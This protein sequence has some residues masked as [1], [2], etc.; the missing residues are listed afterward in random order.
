VLQSK[1]AH[2]PK[3]FRFENWWLLEQDFQRTATHSWRKTATNS[4]HT[5]TTHLA[6]DLKHWSKSKKPIHQQLEFIESELLHLQSAHPSQRN[7]NKEATL[8]DQHHHLL[9]KNAEY[10]QQRVKKAWVCK[11]DRNTD[12]FHQA[13][14]K[15]TRKNRISFIQDNQGNTTANSQEIATVFVDYFTNLFKTQLQ[16]NSTEQTPLHQQPS[17]VPIND[18][19][20]MSIPD[21]QEIKNI[22]QQMKR[23]A[24]P[25]PDGLN[26][27]FYRAAW[28]WIADDI[29]ALVQ[30][31]YNTGQMPNWNKSSILFSK[32]EIL[33]GRSTGRRRVST[34]TLQSMGGHMQGQS[35]R[36]PWH[37]KD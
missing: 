8:T 36:R 22:L 21:K 30:Q 35:T 12:F 34:F 5:R 15:R 14:A 37:K 1:Q 25:G 16:G 4:F 23:D 32:K 10:H 31:F 28:P 7:H 33:V 13:I 17:Q 26:V 2:K 29:T 24:S 3:P 27:A 11:G 19:F 20:S 9:Q 18:E 6:K